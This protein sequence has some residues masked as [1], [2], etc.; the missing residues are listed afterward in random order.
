M[1]YPAA[2]AILRI[3]LCFIDKLLFSARVK[4]QF[5]S[6]RLGAQTISFML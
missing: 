6:A 2:L 5:V 3:L 1:T 4:K